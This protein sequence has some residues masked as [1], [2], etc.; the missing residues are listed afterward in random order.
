MAKFH[1]LQSL[2]FLGNSALIRVLGEED[3]PLIISGRIRS[4]YIK[5]TELPPPLLSYFIQVVLNVQL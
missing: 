4:I 3:E 5:H 1:S 2:R